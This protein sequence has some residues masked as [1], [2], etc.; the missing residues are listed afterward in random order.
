M[1][2]LKIVKS[3]TGKLYYYNKNNYES[4]K[5]RYDEDIYFRQK[6]LNYCKEKIKCKTCNKLVTRSNMSRHK[7]G[8]KHIKLVL[9]NK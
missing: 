7:K 5:N 4:F 8:I 3:N 1:N 2:N 6:H 9:S